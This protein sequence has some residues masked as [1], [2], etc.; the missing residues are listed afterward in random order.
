ECLLPPPPPPASA[1]GDDMPPFAWPRTVQEIE[2]MVEKVVTDAKANLDA[3][4]AL[5]ES[6]LTFEKVIRPLME[7]PNFKTNPLVCQAKHLQHCST[8]ASLREAASKAATAFAAC[9]KEGKTRADV[10]A[11]VKAFAATPE[12]KALPPYE[13]HFVSA[14]RWADC[15]PPLP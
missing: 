13:A 12:A 7:A 15:P 3:V 1:P 9:K 4:A 5:P 11:Q 6:E 14:I 8:D 2:S 10:Y